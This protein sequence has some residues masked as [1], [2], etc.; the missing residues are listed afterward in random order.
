MMLSA[1]KHLN[2]TLRV[3]FFSE[4]TKP[5]R[6]RS[7]KK[8][9]PSSKALFVLFFLCASQHERNVTCAGKIIVYDRIKCSVL[10][11]LFTSNHILN[12][13]LREK[14]VYVMAYSPVMRFF[15]LLLLQCLTSER[16]HANG[17]PDVSRE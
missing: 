16:L 5:P 4:L 2:R 17:S 12:V 3:Y 9:F 13:M 7:T 1:S 11:I 6:N 14:H 15:F 8:V 10:E